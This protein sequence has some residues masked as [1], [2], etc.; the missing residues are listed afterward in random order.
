MVNRQASEWIE[1]FC[2]KKV[3]TA[4]TGDKITIVDINDRRNNNGPLTVM[5][6]ANDNLQK[7]RDN[8][9]IGYLNSISAFQD[10]K[11]FNQ[12]FNIDMAY[13]FNEDLPKDLIIGVGKNIQEYNNKRSKEL[14]RFS[15]LVTQS[16]SNLYT[17]EYFDSCEIFNGQ[18]AFISRAT[19]LYTVSNPLFIKYP[20]TENDPENP[21]MDFEKQNV[22]FG[23]DILIITEYLHSQFCET[24]ISYAKNNGYDYLLN[25]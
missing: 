20:F 5:F 16:D 21:I 8:K 10:E 23:K 24:L 15:S 11:T 22:N 18:Q 25:K 1:N 7:S 19:F 17:Y 12:I 2:A 13:V 3:Y 9:Y 4:S 6:I 14:F